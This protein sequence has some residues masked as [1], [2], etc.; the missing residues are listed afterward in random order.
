[1]SRDTDELVFSTLAATGIP[2]TRNAWTLDKRPNPP[3]FI[4]RL[5][6]GGETYA[7]NANYA[8]LPR[9]RAE[10]SLGDD[11]PALLEAF[12]AAVA[13]LGPY[14]YGEE[15]DADDAMPVHTFDFTAF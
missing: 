2:G 10:L 13:S 9:Y 12:T 8:A 7:D 5:D 11:D 14:S 4:Y 6:D 15:W 1:M 3:R